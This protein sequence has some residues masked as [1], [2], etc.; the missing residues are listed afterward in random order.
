MNAHPTWGGLATALRLTVWGGI[1]PDLIRGLWWGSRPRLRAGAV[2]ES[3][4]E[5]RPAVRCSAPYD[6][7]VTAGSADPSCQNGR[8]WG[9]GGRSVLWRERRWAGGDPGGRAGRYFTPFALATKSVRWG[10]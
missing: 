10:T 1:A 2:R 4:G 7:W 3:R 6:G 8:M 5:P 9:N